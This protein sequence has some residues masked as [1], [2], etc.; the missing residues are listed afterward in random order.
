[1]SVSVSECEPMR[2]NEWVCTQVTENRQNRQ[3]RQPGEQKSRRAKEQKSQ[4]AKE[5]KSQRAKE[6]KRQNTK[7]TNALGIAGAR[8]RLCV[9]QRR[10]EE[11]HHVLVSARLNVLRLRAGGG[12]G[13]K[14]H[15]LHQM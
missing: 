12:E 2:V 11:L 9:R 13:R 10:H 15:T 5:Q 1:M 14:A 8:E 6:Q 7:G 4:R 3:N